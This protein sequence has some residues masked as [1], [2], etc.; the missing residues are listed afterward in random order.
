MY[1]VIKLSGKQYKVEPGMVFETDRLDGD[2]GTSIILDEDVLLVNDGQELKV[3]T[4]SVAGATV[5]L[6]VL[7]HLRDKK[8]IVFKMKRRKRYR[9]KQGHRQELTRVAVKDISVA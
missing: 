8:I 5:E 1:A 6:E 9:V 7:E 3:G 2:Q 4:P